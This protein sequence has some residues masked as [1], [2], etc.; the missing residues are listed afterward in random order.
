[1]PDD[2]KDVDWETFKA[3]QSRFTKGDQPVEEEPPD[4]ERAEA[5]AAAVDAMTIFG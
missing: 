3:R 1:V 5:T 2:A 4:P